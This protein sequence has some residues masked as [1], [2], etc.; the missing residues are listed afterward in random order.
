MSIKGRGRSRVKGGKEGRGEGERE[1]IK[2]PGEVGN[3][4]YIYAYLLFY[5]AGVLIFREGPC[6]CVDFYL[7]GLHSIL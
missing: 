6:H 4:L 7:I 5:R 2:L 1:Q 3:I